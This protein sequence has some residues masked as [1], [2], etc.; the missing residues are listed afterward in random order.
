MFTC[1]INDNLAEAYTFHN[2][3]PATMYKSSMKLRFKDKHERLLDYWDSLMIPNSG[4]VLRD[5]EAP[6]VIFNTA[7][8][9]ID[10]FIK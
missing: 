6:P 8:K 9:H 4:G 1:K 5:I 3:K 7:Q 2:L 10:D